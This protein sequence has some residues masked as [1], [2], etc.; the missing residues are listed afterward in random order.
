MRIKKYLFL[1]I[2]LGFFQINIFSQ[3]NNLLTQ[4]GSFAVGVN[5]WASY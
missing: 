5:Y 1:L 4:Q 3:E 2:G